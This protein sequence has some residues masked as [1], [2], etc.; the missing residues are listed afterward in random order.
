MRT[1]SLSAHVGGGNIAGLFLITLLLIV[2][3][4]SMGYPQPPRKLVD[5]SGGFMMHI[6]AQVREAPP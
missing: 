2:P 1:G 4:T 5:V 3:V 6:T